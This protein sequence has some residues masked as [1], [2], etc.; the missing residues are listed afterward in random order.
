MSIRPRTHVLCALVG[1]AVVSACDSGKTQE[2]P[3]VPVISVSVA[4]ATAEV[5]P[6]GSATITVNIT[7]GGGYTGAVNLAAEGVPAG[8]TIAAVTVPPGSTTGTL[9]ISAAAGAA[10][11]TATITVR[12]TGTGVTAQTA[13]FA[14]TVREPPGF[15]MTLNPTSLSVAQGASGNVTVNVTRTGGFTGALALSAQGLPA[16]VTIAPVAVAAGAA[17]AT[18][19]VSATAAAAAGASTVT[20]RATG[21]GVPDA[22]ATLALTVTEAGGYTL[23]VAP[24]SVSVAQGAAASASVNITRTGGFAGAIA[25]T[26]TG[27]PTGMTV[28]FDPASVTGTTASVNV[29]AT[30][31]VSAG[32]HSLTIRGS[33]ASLED[34]TATLT[35]TVTEAGG[36]TLALAPASVSVAQGATANT[37]VNVTRT[38]GFAGA[39]ALTATGAPTGMTVT[40]NPASVTGATAAVAV[41]T[42]AAVAVGTHTITVAGASAGLAERTATLTVQ[43][44]SGGQTGGNVTWQFCPVSGLPIW[45]A[46]QNGTGGWSRVTGNAANEYTFPIDARGGVAYVLNTDG[47]FDLSVAYGT[48]QELQMAGSQ[49]CEA[50]TGATKTINGTV[51]GMTALDLMAYIGLGGGMATVMPMT[52]SGFQLRNVQPG[53]VDLVGSR[54]GVTEAGAFL[55]NRLFIQ[56]NLNPANNSSVTVDFNGP[57]SFAPATANLTLSNLAGEEAMLLGMYYTSNGT[58]AFI[59]L[60]AEQSAA[61]TR[62]YTGVPADRQVSGDFHFLMGVATPPGGGEPT[63]QR[64]VVHVFRTIGDRAFNMGPMMSP[65]TAAVTASQPYARLRLSYAVQADYSTY[66]TASFSQTARQASV[67]MSAGYLGGAATAVL[68]VPDFA[69][70]AGWDSNWG[71][72]PGIPTRWSMSAQGWSG[73]AGAVLNMWID[74][75]VLRMAERS[76]TITP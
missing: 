51:A 61:A 59:N 21:T 72:R 19:V 40:F 75:T 69:G 26:A 10:P 34:R 45:V 2:P 12:A 70:V 42:T 55:V 35:V 46:A 53:P 16:G 67:N 11:T 5:L 44:T 41:A 30:T 31:A 22:T 58:M 76:G 64:S 43:V 1:V 4:A 29:A 25:L 37:T 74:N 47:S 71:P 17:S 57:H 68:E 52:G 18:L 24:A 49:L 73:A 60:D 63:H 13:T 54:I 66:F 20:I 27:A 50:G 15:T 14:L 48:R 32:S 23:A 65:V 28:T 6:G 9:S 38:G 33:A 8:V 39:I 36:Y 56:R 62:S 7:R 3:P